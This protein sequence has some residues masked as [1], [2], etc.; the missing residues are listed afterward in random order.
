MAGTRT[1]NKCAQRRKKLEAFRAKRKAQGKP[2][3]AAA[4]GAV[5]AVTEVV[6]QTLGIHGEVEDDTGND[7][8]RDSV[9]DG[10]GPLD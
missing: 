8:G 9:S 2:L 3:Q 7:E 5:L 10:S 4:V 6:G 1:C